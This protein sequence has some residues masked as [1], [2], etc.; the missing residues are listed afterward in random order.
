[1]KPENSF[2]CTI[3]KQRGYKKT[4]PTFKAAVNEWIVNQQN[5]ILSP[6]KNNRLKINVTG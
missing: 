5:L 2:W 6:I 3:R 1:M 4:T